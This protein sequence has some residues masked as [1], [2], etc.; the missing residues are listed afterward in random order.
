MRSAP[1]T[2]S[3]CNAR[4]GLT[5]LLF[6]IAG[7]GAGLPSP[8]P[9]SA[10]EGDETPEEVGGQLWLTFQAFKPMNKKQWVSHFE[11]RSNGDQ[12][13]ATWFSL[14]GR[15]RVNF[16][17]RPWL[18]LFPEILLRYTQQREDLNSFTVNVRGG[19]RFRVPSTQEIFNRERVPLQRFDVSVLLRLEWRNFFYG[20]GIH[21]SSWRARGRAEVRVPLNHDNMGVDRTVYLRGDAEVF[22]PL[23]DESPET[24]ANRWRFRGGAGYR[25]N[26]SWRVEALGI[27]QRSRNT[28]QDDFRTTELMLNLR[29]R[30]FFQ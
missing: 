13:A 27:W 25:I 3:M 20:R 14:D 16:Y 19:V 4:R 18:D 5:A 28:F 26:F 10:Q 7:L 29:L 12:G 2:G 9:A 17:P 15:T 23:G 1:Q 11:G 21:D 30:H 8:A 6:S 24:F 22:L